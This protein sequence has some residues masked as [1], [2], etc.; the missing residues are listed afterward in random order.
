[1]IHPEI[2][3]FLQSIEC[4]KH[5][6]QIIFFLFTKGQKYSLFYKLA[7]EREEIVEEC[8]DYKGVGLFPGSLFC[9]IDLCVCFYARTCCFDYYSLMVQF[10]MRW[11]DFSNFVL[12]SQDH[13][14]YVGPFVGPYNF[15]KY[16][17]QFG[18]ICHWNLDRNY[19]ESIDCFG[20]YGHFND[21]NSSN[22]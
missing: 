15:L 6:A 22:P 8:I 4:G 20:N 1:M 3:V 16:L 12:L 19:I 9:F 13:C 11:H 10:A 5:N 21:V 18:E 2:Q 14:C 17:F 7:V